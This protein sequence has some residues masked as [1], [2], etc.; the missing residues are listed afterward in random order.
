[1]K[2]LIDKFPNGQ[3]LFEISASFNKI[4]HCVYG[5]MNLYEAVSF[6]AQQNLEQQEMIVRLI[7][8]TPV[9]IQPIIYTTED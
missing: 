7:E 8:G 2:E 4:V 6:F 9:P 3:E 1:M 5:G